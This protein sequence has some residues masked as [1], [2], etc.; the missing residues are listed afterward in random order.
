MKRNPTAGQHGWNGTNLG[1]AP[2][3]SGVYLVYITDALGTVTA[4]GKVLL[5]RQ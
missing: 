1:G 3:A 5:I 2:A 4:Q